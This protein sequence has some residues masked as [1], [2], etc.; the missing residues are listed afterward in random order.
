MAEIHAICITLEEISRRLNNISR[1]SATAQHGTNKKPRETFQQPKDTK[2][3]VTGSTLPTSHAIYPT[4]VQHTQR[5]NDG[6][7]SDRRLLRENNHKIVI[8]AVTQLLSNMCNLHP[9]EVLWARN[10]ISAWFGRV[11]WE[12][13][14]WLWLFVGGSL[15]R[16]P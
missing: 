15:I 4:S 2:A 5:V 8:P 10:T 12:S 11:G 7:S 3:T 13:V 9:H 6:L 16:R 1:I 14:A